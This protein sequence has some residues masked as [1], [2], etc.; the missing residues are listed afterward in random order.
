[1]GFTPVFVDIE[2]D[3][4]NIDVD[5]CERVL[6]NDPDIKVI[7]FAHVL[8]NPP[9]M[10]QLMDRIREIAAQL[11]HRVEGLFRAPYRL[12]YQIIPPR[13]ESAHP[14]IAVIFSLLKNGGYGH[15][16]TGNEVVTPHVTVFYNLDNS[17]MGQVITAVCPSVDSPIGHMVGSFLFLLQYRMSIEVGARL[18]MLDNMTE[19]PIRGAEGIYSMLIYK[20]DLDLDVDEMN[21]A[22]WK[23]IHNTYMAPRTPIVVNGPEMVGVPF[24]SNSASQLEVFLLWNASLVRIYN[25]VIQENEQNQN[26]PW[27]SQSTITRLMNAFMFPSR[28]LSSRMVPSKKEGGFSLFSINR[29][30]RKRS[31]K[32]RGVSKKS[33]FHK[34]ITKRR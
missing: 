31:T 34:K 16:A 15:N 7:T 20:H 29:T 23:L 18:F 2:L 14:N 3:T 4:L 12:E 28:M 19:D 22:Q 33:T 26:N 6:A 24:T 27:K 32:K 8:G 9:N 25:R 30:R 10:D 1:V 17:P 21:E 13:A 5:H 11:Q